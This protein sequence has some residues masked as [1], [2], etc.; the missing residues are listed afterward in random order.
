MRFWTSSIL[1]H[2]G[3]FVAFFYL[4]PD[5]MRSDSQKKINGDVIVVDF[6]Y[7]PLVAENNTLPKPIEAIKQNAAKSLRGQVRMVSPKKVLPKPAQG[8]IKVAAPQAP[9]SSEQ[10]VTKMLKTKKLNP[11]KHQPV[12]P[13]VSVLRGSSVI[14]TSV[15]IKSS[16]FRTRSFRTCTSK[17]SV[18][19]SRKQDEDQENKQ[20]T[21]GNLVGMH[22]AHRVV[23]QGQVASIS[24]LLGNKPLGR[25]PNIAALLNGG[26][27]Q[28]AQISC[29]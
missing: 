25:Q 16:D 4:K 28:S 15:P 13:R 8:P 14:A 6:V 26:K 9:E 20:I 23:L 11:K 5:L 24:A 7:E 19:P 1:L 10:T 3:F 21:I 27:N 17:S 12:A 22:P 2:F 18:K 29:K